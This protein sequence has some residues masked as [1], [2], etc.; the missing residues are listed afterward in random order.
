M[1]TI[2]YDKEEVLALITKGADA[3][4]WDWDITTG[5]A[6]WS[7]SY[8]Q[9]LGYEPKE[10]QPTFGT[11]LDGLVH[12]EDR[13]AID[14]AIKAHI[15]YNT[16]YILEIRLKTKSGEYRWFETSGSA[17]RDENGKAIHMSGV[18]IN[19]HH[20]IA[21]RKELELSEYLLN[22]SGKIAK[23]AG[24]EFTPGCDA[25]YMSDAGYEIYGFEKDNLPSVK[26]RQ[27]MIPE[28]EREEMI[29]RLNAC[30]IDGKEYEMEHRLI[31]PDGTVKWVYAKGVPVLDSEGKTISVRGVTQDITDKKKKE[32]EL[33]T[34]YA[35]IEE[36]NKRL[37]NFAHIVTHNLR[38]H[39]ANLIKVTEILEDAD[40]EEERT[41]MT[42]FV[43][44]LGQS[45]YE[46]INSLNE[47]VQI[48]LH[49]KLQKETL[50][51]DKVYSKIVNVLQA[52]IKEKKATIMTDFSKCPQIESVPSYLESILLNFTTNAIKYSHPDREPFIKIRTMVED[53]R[54]ALIIEDNGRGI[55]L[56]QYGD[57]L[58]GMYK[59]F[60][61]NPDARGVGLFITKNQIDAL[62]GDIKVSSEPNVGTT[63]KILF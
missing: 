16:P 15:E 52:S 60:H 12:E 43:K 25:A 20:K 40:S 22:E 3:A 5:K 58:F 50:H 23:V 29:N 44:K 13:A 18:I 51:F 35:T 31:M 54:K 38:S 1:N 36:Q 30:F 47:I 11:F 2:Q 41:E 7:D 28:G 55:D 48:Q 33:K 21:L 17:K 10:I 46:T 32:E 57:K 8:Y 56:A 53:G 45:L 59:T 39:S 4:I 26:V 19:R 14:S 34:V 6:W 63:F 42:G 24:W 27:E 37:L 61:G 62:G 9:L 49:P